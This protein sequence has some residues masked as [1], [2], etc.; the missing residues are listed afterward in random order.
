MA[1]FKVCSHCKLSQYIENFNLCSRSKDGLQSW[2]K[3]CEA[4]YAHTST[5]L[6]TLKSYRGTEARRESQRKYAKSDKGQT[7]NRRHVASDRHKKTKQVWMKTPK[8]KALAARSAHKRRLRVQGTLCDLTSEEWEEIKVAQN[9]RCAIC[10]EIK[11]LTRDHII[12]VFYGGGLT[13]SNIQGLCGYC[14]SKKGIVVDNG[15]L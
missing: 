12:P 8:G 5:R 13:K 2:C 1:R 9:Y 14:N 15:S 4:E 11:T 3:S 7:V 6:F 10:G